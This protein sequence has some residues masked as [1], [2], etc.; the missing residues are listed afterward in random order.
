M[1]IPLKPDRVTRV[2]TIVILCLVL[3]H[4]AGRLAAPLFENISGPN[5]AAMFDM[6]GEENLPAFCSSIGL[7]LCAALFAV[8]A[9]ATRQGGRPYALH[10]AGLAAIFAFLAAD[11]AITLHEALTVPVRTQLGTSGVLHFAWVIPYSILLIGFLAAYRRF[12][13]HL[14]VKTRA[15]I[16]AAGLIYCSGALGLELIGGQ[17]IELYGDTDIGYWLLI[18]VEEVLEMT[19]TLVLIRALLTYIVSEVGEIRFHAFDAQEGLAC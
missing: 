7:L 12:V 10:W 3:G 4:V 16:V 6:D 19:G 8:I 18:T 15:L 14:P 5:L 11:E 1:N 13:F 2:V 9:A 17:Y